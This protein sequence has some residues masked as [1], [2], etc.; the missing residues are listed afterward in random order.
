MYGWPL[1]SKGHLS[2]PLLDPADSHLDLKSDLESLK[3]P[4]VAYDEQQA[5]SKSNPMADVFTQ[6]ESTDMWLTSVLKRLFKW[7]VSSSK[8]TKSQYSTNH[9]VERKWIENTY[10]TEIYTEKFKIYLEMLL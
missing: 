2:C 3:Y 1:V 9:P 10:Y 6:A 7:D 5:D 8:D 4:A